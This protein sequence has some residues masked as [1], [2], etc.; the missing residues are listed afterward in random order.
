MQHEDLPESR[1][2]ASARPLVGAG[3]QFV[4]KLVIALREGYSAAAFARDAL[5]G[6]TVAILALPLSMAI[7]IGAGVT[8]DRGL[9]TSVIAGFLISAFGGSRYQIGGPAAAFIVMIATIVDKHGVSGLLTATFLAGLLLVV[10]ALL[11]LGTYIKYVPGPVILGFTSGVGVLIAIGQ[12]KDLLGFAGAVPADTIAKL[13]ALWA[14]KESLNPSALLVG[15][16]TLAMISL[17]KA[18]RPSWPGLLIAV[19]GAS[20]IAFLLGLP[21]DT[22]GSRFGGIPSTLPAPALPDLS[23]ATISALLPSIF[24]LAFLIAIES[25]LSAVAADAKTGGRHRSNVEILG[26]GLANIASPLFG[27]IPATGVIA[28]TATNI[29]A[30]G[31]TPVAGILHA[32]FVLL[33]MLLLAPLASH[34]ALPCLAAVLLNV[35]WRLIDWREVSHFIA[36]APFDDRLILLVTLVLTVF[37]SLEVAIATGV[38]LGCILFMHRMAEAT[39]NGVLNGDRPNPDLDDVAGP[40]SAILDAVLPP[41]VHVLQLRGP[42]FFGGASAIGGAVRELPIPPKVLILRMRDVPLVDATALSAIEDVAADLRQRGGR[43]IIS[44]LQKQ[45]RQ[46]M[47]RMGLL[48]RHRVLLASNSFMALEKAKVMIGAWPAE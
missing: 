29:S 18:W 24:T 1:G 26:Q 32:M 41:G 4:P 25:L 20:G 7:A 8:P 28:R 3:S 48:R 37:A 13:Q 17:L 6:F 5:A 19:G 2:G 14:M 45:P 44:G 16:G 42:L 30:G 40:R 47:H 23:P 39:G 15:L 38:G 34:L 9:V 35:S 27:G 12:I 22:I 10:L 43:L 33:F 36:R 31:K 11:R 21:I 46:A